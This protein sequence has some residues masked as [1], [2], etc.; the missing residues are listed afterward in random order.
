MFALAAA[1]VVA[2]A[3]LGA[4][5]ATGPLADAWHPVVT[6]FGQ[7]AN[8]SDLRSRM[9]IDAALIEA[10]RA[11]LHGLLSAGRM[12]PDDYNRATQI[13]DATAADP[14]RVAVDGLASDIVLRAEAASRGVAPAVDIAVELGRAAQVDAS[15]HVRAVVI[16]QPPSRSVP[17]AGGWPSPAG[18]GDSGVT[19]AAARAAAAARA[20]E[21]L[22]SGAAESEVAAALTAAGWRASVV[23]Q[24]IGPTGAVEGIPDGLVAALRETPGTAVVADDGS[25]DTDAAAGAGRV[26]DAQA[27]SAAGVRVSGIDTAA[28]AAWATS[29]A[30]ERV[31][32][33]SLLDGWRTQV[34][35][36]VRVAEVV[37]GP[38]NPGVA[39]DYR[40]FAHLVIGQLPSADHGAGSDA[41]AASRLASELRALDTDA[42]TRRFEALMAAADASHPADA[43]RISGETPFLTREQLVSALGDFAFAPYAVPGDV[44]GPIA[45]SAG[46]ELFLLRARFVGT[47]DDRSNAAAVEA[48]S[49][50]D[51]LAMARRVAPTGEWPRADGTLWRAQDEG[52]GDAGAAAAFGSTMLGARSDP[53]TLAG[54]IVVAQP[55][56]RSTGPIP[57]GALTR[58]AVRGFDAWLAGRI[59]AAGVVSDPEPLPGITVEAASPEGGGVPSAGAIATPR[60]PLVSG[61]P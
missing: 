37:I 54:E 25:A 19:L 24:W 26:V 29:R 9:A 40:S 60:I 33:A 53:F 8:R 6:A 11:S 16:R 48:R 32:R 1:V 59:R 44:L 15:L 58:L 46:T 17:E 7:T 13:V 38:A 42:R 45:T 43:L 34:H 51:L 50:D 30:D 41:E 18:D 3:L 28:L 39:G 27:T 4:A 21:A 10:R 36:V 61:L 12:T 20:T 47:L 52:D 14:L 23:D 56:E 31:L 55:L 22:R 5:Y 57:A 35:P 49:T 2:L